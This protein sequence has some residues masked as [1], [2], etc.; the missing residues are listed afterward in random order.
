MGASQ[1]EI[2]KVYGKSSPSPYPKTGKFGYLS[3]DELGLL[4]MLRDGALSSFV[5]SPSLKKKP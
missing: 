3:Y 1:D 2:E 5:A 4:F